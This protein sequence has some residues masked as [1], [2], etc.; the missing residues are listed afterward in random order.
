M[1]KKRKKKF[2]SR[3]YSLW[4]ELREYERE[5]THL[6]LENSPSRADDIVE[7]CM[8]AEDSDYMRDFVGDERDRIT[9]I[10]F[11]RV[12]EKGKAAGRPVS[13]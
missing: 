2:S 8:L 13:P 6:Y 9:E 3:A 7:A 1:V 5:G 12:S 10:H 4:R 11:I